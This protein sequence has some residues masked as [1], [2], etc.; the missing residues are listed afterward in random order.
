MD[1]GLKK[2]LAQ[3]HEMSKTGIF[4]EIAQKDAAKYEQ[5]EKEGTQ[6]FLK[7]IDDFYVPRK[8]EEDQKVA[9]FADLFCRLLIVVYREAKR[10][11][12]SVA[13][14]FANSVIHDL[15]ART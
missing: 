12:Q 2:R 14:G 10:K 9:Q 11:D 6:V 3:L 8:T 15:R 4:G 7:L 5:I 13:V 1:E